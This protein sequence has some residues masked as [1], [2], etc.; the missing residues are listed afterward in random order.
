MRRIQMSSI[1]VAVV[2][3]TKLSVTLASS[4]SAVLGANVVVA[5]LGT[6]VVVELFISGGAVVLEAVVLAGQQIGSA[7]AF[8]P[9]HISLSSSVFNASTIKSPHVLATVMAVSS[10]TVIPPSL[11]SKIVT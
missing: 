2:D 3:G 7:T 4:S 11:P 8:I 10:S 1:D 5:K 9:E 6:T